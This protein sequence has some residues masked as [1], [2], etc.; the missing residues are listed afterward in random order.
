MDLGVL[1]LQFVGTVIGAMIGAYITG[2]LTETGRI[3][4]VTAA[5]AKVVEQERA[6]A[7]A[8]EQGKQDAVMTNLQHLNTQM[9]TLTTTQEQ[10]KARVSNEVWDRQWR[11]NRKEDLYTKLIDVGTRL[12]QL[13]M[14][15]AN[16]KSVTDQKDDTKNKAKKTVAREL[17]I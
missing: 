12:L 8:Q 14:S 5:L 7:F 9:A 6:K 16:Q 10:I 17:L 13:C 3:N 2:R 15:V 1:S 11:L 4:A